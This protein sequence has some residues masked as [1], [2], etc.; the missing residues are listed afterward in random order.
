MC[1]GTTSSSN[2]VVAGQDNLADTDECKLRE[3]EERLVLKPYTI[4][5]NIFFKELSVSQDTESRYNVSSI[6][7]ELYNLQTV[8][9][10]CF[11]SFLSEGRG[12]TT[13]WSLAT[14]TAP[15]AP[16]RMK[17]VSLFVSRENECTKLAGL[18]QCVLTHSPW[19]LTAVCYLEG[20]PGHGFFLSVHNRYH[21]HLRPSCYMWQIPSI[22]ITM[23]KVTFV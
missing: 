15:G 13:D 6:I 19:G 7:T 17:R 8:N 22:Q 21:L 23:Y 18:V 10:T 12:L 2:T 11:H 14:A 1:V 9:L 3:S 20:T 5:L 4:Y 16:T